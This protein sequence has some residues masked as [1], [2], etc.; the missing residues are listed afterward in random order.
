MRPKVSVV[1]TTKNSK[2][3]LERLLKSIKDQTY[4]DIEIIVVDNSSSDE[5]K[6]IARKYT[7]KVFNKGPERSAQ[8][9]F[10]V[11]KAEGDLLLIL[12]SDME[13]TPKVIEDCV[14]TTKRTG[15][16]VLVI[17]EKT[18]GNGWLVR[19]RQFE[20]EMYEGDLSIEVARFFDRKIFTEFGGYDLNLTGPED[21]DLPYRI[22]KKYRIGRAHEYIL[23]HEDGTTLA[24][25]LSKKYY[26]GSQGALYA[27][28]HPELISIQGNLL[29]RK[30]YFR[31]WKKFIRSPFLGTTFIFVRILETV[32][33]VSGYIN[34][35]GFGTFVKSFLKILNISWR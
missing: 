33:A 7:Q 8:R 15:L 17:P 30:A 31:N 35:V 27:Q 5:T 25:L 4:K 10:G 20:R 6:H 18:V 26:Y 24:S 12:D 34:A 19:V 1:I 23:H 14:G 29:F 28:K 2:R 9:N 32:L 3:T 21:Y 13:L 22:S 11:Q 16:R